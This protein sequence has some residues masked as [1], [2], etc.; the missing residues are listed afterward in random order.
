M[1]LEPRSQKCAALAPAC[2]ALAGLSSSRVRARR[3]GLCG[4]VLPRRPSVALPLV[5][6]SASVSDAVAAAQGRV[7]ASA[8]LA[9]QV[10]PALAPELVACVLRPLLVRRSRLCL[11]PLLWWLHVRRRDWLLP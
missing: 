6:S 11:R 5:E 7:R 4:A 3:A 9:L 1:Q 10:A 8:T 2:S